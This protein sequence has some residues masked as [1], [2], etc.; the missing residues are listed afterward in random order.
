LKTGK[1]IR[2]AFLDYFKEAGHEVVKSA[3]LIPRDDPTLLFTNAGMVPFKRV[4]LGEEKRGYVRAASSQK[5]VRA[6]GKHNDLENVGRTARH[7]TFFEML[8]NFSFG[9]YFKA[10]AIRFAWDLLTR[11]YGLPAD[12]LYASVYERDDEAYRLWQQVVSLPTDRIVR[13]GEKDN[14]WSMG[15]TGPCGPCSEIIID[16]GPAFGCGQAACAPGC[17]CD[18]YLELWNLVFMQFNRDAS[19][20]LTPLPKPS[21]DTGMG[22][23]RITAVKQGVP[24]NF[25]SD[26]FGPIIQTIEE[27][28]GIRIGQ[29]ETTDVSIKVIADHSRAL[30]FL[31][32]DGAL[33]SNE[34]RGYV[35]RRILRRAARHGKVLGLDKPFLYRMTQVVAETMGDV[36]PEVRENLPLT[37]QVVQK[38]EERFLE[39]LDFG[40][41]L[42]YEEIDR[43]RQQGE[44]RVPG[45]LI[46]K[47]YDT[48]GFPLDIIQDIARD[49]ELTVDEPGF[50]S[51]MARQREM[52]RQ[53]WKGSG[54]KELQEV[55]RRLMARDLKTEFVGYQDLETSGS[56]LALILNGEEVAA[57]QAPAEVEVITAATPFY[58]ESG[59]Q[60]G[61]Q[62]TITGN[63][64][65]L[66]VEETWALPNKTIL[67][68]GKIREGALSVGEAV[69]LSVAADWRTPTAR[70]HSA[71]HLLHGALRRVLGEHIKQAGSLVTPKRLRF[72]FTCFSAPSRDELRRVEDL[73]NDVIRQNLAI[74]TEVT[75]FD[76]AVAGG[77]MALFEEKYGDQVRLVRMGDFSRELCGG[78]HTGRTGDIGFFK[79]FSEGSVAAGVRRIEALTGPEALAEVHLREDQIQALADL[80][81]TGPEDLNQ[82]VEKLLGQQKDLERTIARLNKT[83]MTGSGVDGI[84]AKTR[85]VGGVKILAAL[86]P[87]GEAKELR[88]LADSLRDLL[89]SGIVILGGVQDEKALLVTVVTKDLL[90]RFHAGKIIQ[91]IAQAVGGKGGGRPDMA[92][93]G[94]TK[95]ELLEQALA[96][97]YEWIGETA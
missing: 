18:R 27:L 36:Y 32:A 8:G 30:A 60:V 38:E 57:A 2:K 28:S 10:E 68:R 80:L 62:G 77:A 96:G 76:Q 52:S 70:N 1:E 6:G 44:Q 47:L 65:W 19:G 71:T 69:S 37:V 88:D 63:Q 14:F 12:K 64:G 97:V 92:Q 21:I 74:G 78:T 95:P 22:L 41:K 46:F 3:S 81:K 75:D 93:A 84:L 48:Y 15:E 35:I 54:E 73:V 34:G 72:D 91:R 55:Y 86:A 9:D 16:Q 17:D 5:C 29:Q 90:P 67:H 23:E 85:E 24:N 89:G 33:P 39:T 26:L 43:L 83:L 45:A 40:L 42:L 56:V 51:H 7:H 79:I 82:R 13:L 31:M 4:F 50:E 20:T 11:V 94:G 87:T 53:S 59:G 49:Q 25:A 61:D 66:I 58:A